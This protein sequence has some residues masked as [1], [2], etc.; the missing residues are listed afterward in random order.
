[1]RQHLPIWKRSSLILKEWSSVFSFF[2]QIDKEQRDIVFYSRQAQYMAFF[3]GLID[4]LVHEYGANLCYI[5][6]DPRDPILQSNSPNLISFYFNTLFPFV[7]PFLKAK[8][9]VLTMPDL[10]QFHIKRSIYDTNHVYVFHSMMSTHMIY[11]LGAF[12]H[13]DTI[14]CVGPY[15]LEEIRRAEDA[16]GL[17][18]KCL[19]EVGYYRVEKIY[20]DHQSYLKDYPPEE[21]RR[22]CILIAPGWHVANIIEVCARELIAT[23]LKAEYD[24]ILRPHPMTIAKKPGQLIALEN[25]FGSNQGFHLDIESVSEKS[26]HKADVLISDWSGVALEYAFGTERPVLFIDLPRKVHNPEYEKIGVTPIEVSLREHIGQVISIE[27][28]PNAALIVS[29]FL[30]NRNVYK[31]KIVN[32]RKRNVYN[33]GNSSKIGANYIMDIYHGRLKGESIE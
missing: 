18:P 1:M 25:E 11:R 14:F 30:T 33:F 6:S 5:T 4:A 32:A 3:E 10:N 12:D 28:I 9:V 23:L 24:V 29:N 19:L 21:K 15:H 13:Y 7:L 27:D 22:N 26:L 31:D 20:H 2:R 16:Y 17:Q 8:A